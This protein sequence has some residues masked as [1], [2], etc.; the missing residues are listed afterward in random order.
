M[1][2]EIVV[3]TLDIGRHSNAYRGE[4]ALVCAII[5][6]VLEEIQ[7]ERVDRKDAGMVADPPKAEFTDDIPF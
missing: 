3:E 4:R 5:E 6:D 7:Y 1:E 2:N